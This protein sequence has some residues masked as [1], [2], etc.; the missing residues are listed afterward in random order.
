[1]GAHLASH[2]FTSWVQ[3]SSTPAGGDRAQ[4]SETI[5]A[6]QMVVEKAAKRLGIM[7]DGSELDRAWRSVKEGMQSAAR[8]AATDA[9]RD[10]WISVNNCFKIM[11]EAMRAKCPPECVNMAI[12]L[13][14]SVAVISTMSS[15]QGVNSDLLQQF[16][17]I[18]VDLPDRFDEEYSES[19]AKANELVIKAMTDGTLTGEDVTQL[20][21]RLLWQV[22]DFLAHF[23]SYPE[24]PPGSGLPRLP[25]GV[26]G[27]PSSAFTP[28]VSSGAGPPTAG[29]SPSVAPIGVPT[30]QPVPSSPAVSA[31]SAAEGAPTRT[32]PLPSVLTR[33]P[34]PL[35]EVL[36]GIRENM[37]RTPATTGS[38]TDTTSSGEGMMSGGF[39]HSGG[40]LRMDGFGGTGL[41]EDRMGVGGF[42]NGFGYSGTTGQ[43]T[44]KADEEATKE[45]DDKD[46]ESEKA[47]KTVPTG[48]VETS[49]SGTG[50]GSKVTPDSAS[51]KE[52]A[53]QGDSSQR[54]RVPIQHD[55]DEETTE[56]QAE[57]E[58]VVS[59]P[60]E[61][62]EMTAEEYKALVDS[63]PLEEAAKLIIQVSNDLEKMWNE[64]VDEVSGLLITKEGVAANVQKRLESRKVKLEE[65]LELINENRQQAQEFLEFRAG[66][67]ETWP[68]RPLKR[69]PDEEDQMDGAIPL[70]KVDPDVLQDI[71]QR[72]ANP[73]GQDTATSDRAKELLQSW[74]ILLPEFSDEAIVSLAK[75][76]E[77]DTEGKTRP[78]LLEMITQVW[79]LQGFHK[80][81]ASTSDTHQEQATPPS[82]MS[83]E[84]IATASV[85]S[86]EQRVEKESTGEKERRDLDEKEADESEKE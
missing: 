71:L 45:S 31:A 68:V 10:V 13:F 39:S 66:R 48:A 77:I 23:K 5:A 12:F 73:V 53:E 9:L 16:V 64:D 69:P 18:A 74:Y 11:V 27:G 26:S 14:S 6:S 58:K 28:G 42:S 41:R 49:T 61:G 2:F 85:A 75:D 59:L 3:V 34:P 17:E 36:A 21:D 57:V 19:V 29:F 72:V 25:G 78:A 76:L 52:P 32:P 35:S 30:P 65:E 33:P 54:V 56:Q 60:E 8:G 46:Q 37:A 62:E 80:A 55:S 47:M 63:L 70:Q 82:L 84:E 44:E 40:M 43:M 7:E 83:S 51:S 22:N 1:M 38:A 4:L 24:P 67:I 86:A 79:S 15:G 50:I 20:T 81:S